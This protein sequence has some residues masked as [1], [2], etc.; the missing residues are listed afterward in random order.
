MPFKQFTKSPA[1]GGAPAVYWNFADHPNLT[2]AEWGEVAAQAAELSPISPSSRDWGHADGKARAAIIRGRLAG[3][4]VRGCA[5]E[6][7]VFHGHN[8]PGWQRLRGANALRTFDNLVDGLRA[9]RP[10]AFDTPRA[11]AMRLVNFDSTDV[12]EED[13]GNGLALP[14]G[15]AQREALLRRNIS[16]VNAT[17]IKLI[18]R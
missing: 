15:N 10:G 17:P 5:E 13:A 14:Q 11:V 18:R 8:L 3:D 2:A 1:A 7:E 9:W 12:P 4:Q 6:F 16:N